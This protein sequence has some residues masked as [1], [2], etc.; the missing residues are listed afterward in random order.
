[1]MYIHIYIYRLVHLG[2]IH[3][4]A[5]HYNEWTI[6]TEEVSSIQGRPYRMAPLQTAIA[7]IYVCSTAVK[8]LH[9]L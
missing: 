7:S 8:E 6:V 9:I 1:M 5:K 2:Y 4:T 3:N